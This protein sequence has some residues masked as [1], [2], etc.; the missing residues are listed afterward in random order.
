[1][2][3][4]DNTTRGQRR[5]PVRAFVMGGAMLALAGCATSPFDV[6]F[7]NL[8]GGGLN[9][10]GGSQERLVADRPEPD[11]RGIISYPSYQVAVAQR[12]DTLTTL[13]QRIGLAPAELARFNG[14]PVTAPLR[15]GELIVLP[16]RVAEPPDGPIEITS[17][18]GAALDRAENAGAGGSAAGAQA[19]LSRTEPARHRVQRG[20]TAY[21]IARA[22]NV[23]VRALADWNGLGPS[24]TVREGQFLLIPPTAS[25]ATGPDTAAPGQGSRTPLPPSAS[26]PLPN[27][28]DV[29]ATPITPDLSGQ[30]TQASAARMIMPVD[31]RIIRAYQRGKTDGIDISA[32]AG[33]PVRAAAAGTVAAITRDTENVPILVIRHP[34]NLLTVY[35]NIDNI[36]VAKGDR[37]S[38][39]QKIA[40]VR[41]GNPAFLHFQVREG[42]QSVDP[43]GY[44]N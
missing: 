25:V 1:M 44:L 9:F 37:V 26:R 16:G 43:E 28:P 42:T 23:S 19:S 24:M 39:G 6:D 11:A 8:V 21:S 35:A 13:A 14:L 40:Q 18:A 10:P 30:A 7:R 22:Y 36:T 15:E 4:H 38:K 34:G 2:A 31:G 32:T 29:V 3:V 33:S 12:G 17:L 41:A 5:R 20:E 27:A